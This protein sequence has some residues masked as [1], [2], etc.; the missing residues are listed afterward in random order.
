MA[1]TDVT[2][3]RDKDQN[4]IPQYY[5]P[6]T[7]VMEPLEG[8]YGANSFIER[9]RLVKDAFSGSS[10]VTKTYQ[11]NMYGFGIVN[12]GASDLTVTI[13]G[14]SIVVKSGEAFDD[15]FDPFKTLTITG[16]SAFRAVVRQ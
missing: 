14:F 5:N 1:Y 2:I 13:N 7:G 4:P 12:D 9:G 10:T 3:L 8:S 15:L 11:N 16:T 6:E